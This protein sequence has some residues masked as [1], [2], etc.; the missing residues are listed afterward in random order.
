MFVWRIDCISLPAFLPSHLSPKTTTMK[1]KIFTLIVSFIFIAGAFA[2]APRKVVVEDYTGI[3]CGWCP[4]GRTAT[5]HLDAT[6][7]NSVICMGVHSGDSLSGSTAGNMS[8]Y[9]DSLI[10]GIGVTGFPEGSIDRFSDPQGGIFQGCGSTPTGNDWDATVTKRLNTTSPVAVNISNTYNYS[11]RALSVTVTA[12]FVASAS[13]NMRLNCVLAED[14]IQTLHVQHNYMTGDPNYSA[15]EWYSQADPIAVYY[16]RDVARVNLATCYGAKGVIPTSVVSGSAYS[17]TYTYTLPASWNYRHVKIVG[18]VSKWGS[19]PSV[20]DTSN[21]YIIN[22]NVVRLNQST[23]TGIVE[24]SAS[25]FSVG[26]SYPNPFS[27]ATA[28]PVQLGEDSRMSIKVYNVLGME[29]ATLVDEELMAGEHT[30]FW[31]GTQ[32][33]GSFS[34][35]GL[36]VIRISTTKGSV[37][38]TVMLSR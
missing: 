29:V 7:G 19:T 24:Q 27:T 26:N 17:K 22:A 30:F 11:T 21:I 6:Y 32:Q 31:A 20:A 25:G 15:Y 3:W 9:P 33:D 12:N 10:N 5:Q 34:K 8:G 14:S 13:G 16:Q 2:Q 35:N 23:T 4:N 38:H 28:I 36:Y 18:F 37:S 1:R